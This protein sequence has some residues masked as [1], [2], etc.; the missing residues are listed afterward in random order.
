MCI[1]Y[2]L[3]YHQQI[4][5]GKVLVQH[6]VK[7]QGPFCRAF[8]EY[9]HHF[10]RC[11][12]SQKY[13]FHRDLRKKITMK[14]VKN[15]DEDSMSFFNFHHAHTLIRY[16]T[17]SKFLHIFDNFSHACNESIGLLAEQLK[18]VYQI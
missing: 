3:F 9:P 4:L 7:L 6:D 1:P 18:I 17:N 14:K 5:L 16:R 10:R 15:Q 12:F 13:K 11:R 2:L 8:L